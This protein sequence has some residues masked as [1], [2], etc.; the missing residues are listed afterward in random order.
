[1]KI[2]ILGAGNIGTIVARRLARAGHDVRVANSRAP[3]TVDAAALSTGAAPVWAKDVT[4]G[5]DVVVVSVN[6]GQIPA[7][8]DLVAAA[9]AGATVID[10][11]NYM[12]ARDGAVEGFVD[13]QVESTYVQEQYR[14]PVAKA[15]NSIITA[16]F[17]DKAVPVGT[18]GRIA[19][20]VSADDPAHRA[21]ATE[22]VEATG[23]DAHD[24]GVIADSWRQQPGTPAYCTDRT[25]G[26]LPA[27][28]A[29]A[30][31]DRSTRRRD[32]LWAVVAERIEAEGTLPGGDRQLALIRAIF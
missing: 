27:V 30:D 16:S 28:L 3:E 5:A 20:P 1:M 7:V 23:F 17:A 29:A 4:A 14:R 25:A 18:P 2:G 31:R 12:P 22:L 9:P 15:W 10:T 26:E 24:A 21:V 32:L 19:L 6:F 13:G 8:A 11:S